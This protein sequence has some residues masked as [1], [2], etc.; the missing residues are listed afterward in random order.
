MSSTTTSTTSTTSTTG[1]S[2]ASAV[3]AALGITTPVSPTLQLSLRSKKT[4]C[5]QSSPAYGCDA[6]L[7]QFDA[8]EY[9]HIQYSADGSLIAYVHAL[10]VAIHKADSGAFYTKLDR[11]GIVHISFSPV[12]SYML[13]WERPTEANNNENNLL[14]WDITVAGGNANIIYRASQRNCNAEAWPLIKWTDD[15][16]IAGR[17]VTNEI[18]FF[19]GRNIG[20][21]AKH[22]K[23]PHVAGFEFAP[24]DAPYKFSTFVPENKS[25]PGMCRIYVYPNISEHASHLSF[26]KASEAIME[27]NRKGTSLLIHTSTDTD[28]TGKS[29]YGETG[30][31]F[32]ALDGTSYTLGIKGP[33]HD[34]KWSPTIDQFI[35]SY[36]NPFQTTLFNVKGTPLVDF[37]TLPRNTI[38]FSPNGK[39]LM[40]GGFGNL[41]GDMDFWDLTKFRKIIS[42]HAHCA[43]LTEWAADSVHFVVAFLSPRIRVDNGLKVIKYDGSVI[44]KEAI[45]DLYQV[46]WRPQ[47]PLA[48][49]DERI[50]MPPASAIKETAPPAK[51]TPPSQ[52][53]A[54]AAQA[55][56]SQKETVSPNPPGFKIYTVGSG[57]SSSVAQTSSP[58]ERRKPEKKPSK[59]KETAQPPATQPQQPGREKSPE[60]LR[61]KKIKALEKKLKEIEQLRT[62]LELGE[63]MPPTAI[64]KVHNEVRY[65]EELNQMLRQATSSTSQQQ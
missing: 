54:L 48:F 51:Y 44:Y 65:R 25:A 30:L 64:E 15:E 16:M 33:I 11:P 35:V 9:K 52:R 29:Y 18:Q 43:T 24:G 14:V 28:K 38:R 46:Q 55:A 37:G 45:P 7:Q 10:H 6:K 23:L 60:E 8:T 32:L 49:P 4:I 39:L 42:T 58:T 41:Q 3:A 1:V 36:G 21:V 22:L 5:S 61:E 20:M 19:N 12:N 62:K 13:T 59:P 40:L 31:W 63:H 26:F 47:N 17:L 53:A 27:W 57:G 34:V 56:T 2:A 50:V